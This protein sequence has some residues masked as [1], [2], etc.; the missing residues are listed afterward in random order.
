MSPKMP[1]FW[2]FMLL[3]SLVSGT[4]AIPLNIAY[5]DSYEM[6]SYKSPRNMNE[7]KQQHIRQ[8]MV[9]VSATIKQVQNILRNDPSLPRL[10]NGEIEDL[11]E[12]V[13][14]EEYKRSIAAG[15]YE[16]AKHMQS[17][18]LVLPFNANS[19]SGERLQVSDAIKVPIK[20]F[21]IIIY[22]N[23]NFSHGLQLQK[24]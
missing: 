21:L 10:T 4:R 9:D 13:T 2:P 6:Y 5:P 24:W 11:F 22:F 16:R 15:D 19:Q 17:L 14:R 18:M 7:L 3:L 23:R 12:M 20:I 1:I 8:A